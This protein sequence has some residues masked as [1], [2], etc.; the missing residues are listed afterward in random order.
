MTPQVRLCP[1]PSWFPVPARFAVKASVPDLH[2]VLRQP[3][4]WPTVAHSS[5]LPCSALLDERSFKKVLPAKA[6]INTSH[7]HAR[8]SATLSWVFLLLLLI[9]HVNFQDYF[10]YMPILWTD[11]VSS[12]SCIEGVL[13]LLPLIPCNNKMGNIISWNG[14]DQEQ[15]Q[16]KSYDPLTFMTAIKKWFNYS[17]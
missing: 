10:V 7:P 13:E 14:Y 4:D 15:Q 17:V 5:L 2:S 11:S 1:I 8:H 12:L 6:S 16:Q 9:L 3:H